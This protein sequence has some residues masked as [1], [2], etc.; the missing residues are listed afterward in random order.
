MN[1]EP[2]EAFPLLLLE[3]VC[4]GIRET[5]GHRGRGIMPGG[6]NDVANL[7]GIR[8]LAK[9][10]RMVGAANHRSAKDGGGRGGAL[11]GRRMCQIGGRRGQTTLSPALAPRCRST[12]TSAEGQA[13]AYFGWSCRVSQEMRFSKITDTWD[14]S[15]QD[16]KSTHN[17]QT[18]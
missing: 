12:A 9:K 6:S 1:L 5:S 13:P 2:G 14:F 4:E 8:A 18:V 7:T 3:I 11:G 17:S 10:N 16:S 15:V